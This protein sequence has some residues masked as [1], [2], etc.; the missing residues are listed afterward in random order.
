MGLS[1]ASR[2]CVR[3]PW[4]TGSQEEPKA[5]VYETPRPM[6]ASSLALGVDQLPVTRTPVREAAKTPPK[7]YQQHV[8][9]DVACYGCGR[10]RQM[11][12]DCWS[13]GVSLMGK[14]KGPWTRRHL[15]NNTRKSSASIV[16][17]KDT[18]LKIAEVAQQ[19]SSSE[20]A[21]EVVAGLFLTR[22]KIIL[23]AS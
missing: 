2:G 22:L 23:S 14:A 17:E 4:H 12:K 9:G 11:K 19:A 8:R 7:A 15:G 21:K 10:K 20:R 6:Q 16:V 18:S 13:N 5:R 3:I 1:M